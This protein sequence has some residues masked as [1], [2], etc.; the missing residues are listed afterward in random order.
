MMAVMHKVSAT[1]GSLQDTVSTKQTRASLTKKMQSTASPLQYKTSFPLDTS[2]SVH[3]TEVW[4]MALLA[5]WTKTEK[6]LGKLDESA[7]SKH[8]FWGQGREGSSP[9]F[10]ISPLSLVFMT[11]ALDMMHDLRCN[12]KA[13]YVAEI[14]MNR[15]QVGLQQLDPYRKSSVKPRVV[16]S[17]GTEMSQDALHIA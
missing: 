7:E 16:H 14:F 12:A 9:V 17:V 6:A 4:R 15:V 10:T 13:H 1:F 3:S 11:A 8:D 2:S 5:S